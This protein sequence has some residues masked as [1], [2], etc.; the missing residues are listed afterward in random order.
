MYHISA[1]EIHNRVEVDLGP[2]YD[3]EQ[4]DFERELKAAIE[5]VRADDGGFDLLADFTGVPVMDQS[6]ADDS[7]KV[8][9]WCA[10]NGLRRSANVVGSMIHQLQVRRLAE[11]DERFAYFETVAEAANWLES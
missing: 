11:S 10:A 3:F 5:Q 7:Q 1:K 8:V 2:D 9:A 6:R 4:D